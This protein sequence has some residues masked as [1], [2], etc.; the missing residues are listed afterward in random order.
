MQGYFF[1]ANGL[2]TPGLDV[3]YKTY[4]R[5]ALTS[6]DRRQFDLAT[7]EFVSQLHDGHTFF[8]DTWLDQSSQPLR[9]YAAPLGGYWVVQSSFLPSLKAGDIIASIDDTPVEEFFQQR[10]RYISASSTA[11]QRHS[12]FLLPYLSP[13]QFTL[14]LDGNRNVRID[15]EKFKEPGQKT[16]GRWL[17]PGLT[18]YVR[19]PAFNQPWFEQS[20]LDS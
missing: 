15:R 19:I 5:T 3:S 10:Q 12:L 4:L 8:W 2:Q 20:A 16:D 7:I 17:K 9:F 18:A 14:T 11:A 13:E 1:S 6:D